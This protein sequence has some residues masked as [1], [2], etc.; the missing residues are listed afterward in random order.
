MAYISFESPEGRTIEK[1]SHTVSDKET[2]LT[3]CQAE[4]GYLTVVE[5]R[6]KVGKDKPGC[7]SEWKTE[8]KV[9]ISKSYPLQKPAKT[10]SEVTEAIEKLDKELFDI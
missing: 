2:T 8:T 6:Y 10:D 9:Y 7:C 1:K 3:I 5:H 4:N